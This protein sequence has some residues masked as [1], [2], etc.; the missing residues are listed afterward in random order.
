MSIPEFHLQSR[1]LSTPVIF[2]G[3][4]EG[5]GAMVDDDVVC[6]TRGKT[7][8]SATPCL[9]R[10][11]AVQVAKSVVA[12]STVI[13]GEYYKTFQSSTTQPQRSVTI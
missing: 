1:R 3:F 2:A 9:A 7:T 5:G 11:A 4:A 12:F 10:S 8:I 6:Q 13:G